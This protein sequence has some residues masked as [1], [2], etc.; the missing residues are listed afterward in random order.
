MIVAVQSLLLLLPEPLGIFGRLARASRTW[1]GASGADVTR[2]AR[3]SW[4]AT[5][6]GAGEAREVVRR[7]EVR[8]T[9]AVKRIFRV[10][11]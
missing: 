10:G 2:G 6:A 7:A 11:I 1:R 9:D 5:G 4:I 8:R 3:A